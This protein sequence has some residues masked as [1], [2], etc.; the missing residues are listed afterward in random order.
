LD[1]KSIFY[2]SKSY[3]NEFLNKAPQSIE[4]IEIHNRPHFFVLLKKINRNYKF[5]LIFHND[6]NLL[7]G[8]KTVEEKLFILKNCDEIIFISKFVKERFYYNLTNYLPI[9]GKIIYHSIKYNKSLSNKFPKKEKIIIFCGKLNSAKGYDVFG[10]A[11]TKILNKYKT[12]SSVVAGNEKRETYNYKHEKLKIYDWISHEKI[13]NLY[14]KSSISF[15]LVSNFAFL[16]GMQD[17]LI[18]EIGLSETKIIAT[19]SNEIGVLV[20]SGSKNAEKFYDF[21][22]KESFLFLDRKYEKFSFLLEEINNLRKKTYK[23]IS[24][25]GDVFEVFNLKE[26]CYKNKI[27]K[28]SVYALVKMQKKQIKGWKLFF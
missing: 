1:K 14:K 22:Y 25:S 4:L 27:S 15:S 8:S 26:F 13:L 23:L 2:N 18:D 11:V 28:K 5:I 10:K 9:K 3:L 17:F 21:L 16:K 7:R 24:P 6:P 20:Y 19:K 12:W